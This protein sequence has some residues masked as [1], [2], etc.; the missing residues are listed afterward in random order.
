MPS[1]EVDLAS[2]PQ[3]EAEIQ[4]AWQ[5]GAERLI[6]DLR[7]VEFMDST[8]IRVIVSAHQHANQSGRWFGIVDGGD[9]VHRLLSLTHLLDNLQVATAPDELLQRH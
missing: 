3:L 7:A 2:A 9:Q 1:G 6:L 8:G 4:Q 5:S